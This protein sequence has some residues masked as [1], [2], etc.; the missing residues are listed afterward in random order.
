[1]APVARVMKLL[2][3]S[4]GLTVDRGHALTEAL[5]ASSAEYYTGGMDPLVGDVTGVGL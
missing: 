3:T 1:M 4:D 2:G 5:G